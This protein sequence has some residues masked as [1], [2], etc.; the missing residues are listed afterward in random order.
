MSVP[1]KYMLLPYVNDC[2]FKQ[3]ELKMGSTAFFNNSN[4][5]NNKKLLLGH[6]HA[7]YYVIKSDTMLILFWIPLKYSSKF[8]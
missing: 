4:L 7:I 8:S 3:G 1:T 6:L 5:V 2:F